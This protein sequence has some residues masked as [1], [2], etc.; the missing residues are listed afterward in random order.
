M[1]RV[2]VLG[3]A[4]GGGVPQWNCNCPVCSTVRLGTDGAPQTQSSIAVSADGERWVLVN[5]SPDIRQQ[6]AQSPCLHPRGLA[7]RS[8]PLAA[9]VLTNADVDHVAGLLSLREGQAFPVYATAR[10]HNVLEAN[11]IFNV[12]SRDLVARR[13]LKLDVEQPLLDAWGN[14]SG[15]RLEAFTVPGKVALW[16]ENPEQEN[17]GSVAE[18]TIGIALRAEGDSK[19]LFYLPGCASVT[20]ELKSRF[21]PD[22]TLLF[23]G[24]TFTECELVTCGVGEKSAA[25]MGHLPMSGKR[26]SMAQLA[27]V[28]LARRLFIHIN[29]TNPALLSGS[30][31]RQ[32]IVRRGWELAFDGMEFDLG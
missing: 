23:D 2:I 4:A 14:D 15:V 19:R 29:N 32:E 11:S 26:G 10:V 7:A 12:L 17:F 20:T 31:E 24:T 18:D 25:R 1:L 27:D 6:L 22:D 30:P 3:A 16:L 8:S 9:V 5:A 21:G 13:A 28:A